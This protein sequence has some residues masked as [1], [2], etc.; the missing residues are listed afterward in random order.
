V[1]LE[2]LVR[3]DLHLESAP[4]LDEPL[5]EQLLGASAQGHVARA[6][7]ALGAAVVAGDAEISDDLGKT[8]RV[9]LAEVE[10][11]APIRPV[12]VRDE[13]RGPASR[14]SSSRFC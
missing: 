3:P 7:A 8:L 14:A 1:G 4:A 10:E 6:E 2:R 5:A 9:E 12:V 13:V 11:R